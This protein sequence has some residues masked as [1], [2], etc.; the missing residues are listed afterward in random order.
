MRLVEFLR[1]RFEQV[2]FHTT[3][4]RHDY[5]MCKKSGDKPIKITCFMH[6][7]HSR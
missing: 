7:A 1:F 6:I 4:R 5:R 3:A 2:A